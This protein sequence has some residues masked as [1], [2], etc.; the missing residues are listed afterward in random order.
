MVAHGGESPTHKANA[1]RHV[2]HAGVMGN[3]INRIATDTGKYVSQ[4]YLHIQHPHFQVLF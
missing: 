3:N 1:R 4:V 2:A